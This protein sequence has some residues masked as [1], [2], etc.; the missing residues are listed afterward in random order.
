MVRFVNV[1]FLVAALPSAVLAQRPSIPPQAIAGPA[2]AVRAV[3]QSEALALPGD[4]ELDQVA[5]VAIDDRGHLFVLHRGDPPLLE[6]ETD[7]SFVRGIGA[8]LFQR[9]HGLTLDPNGGFWVTDV[10]AHTVMHLDS[11]GNVL[12]ALGTPGESGVWDEATG[13]QRFDQPNDVALGPDGHV[14]V[15]Q[16]HGRGDPKILKFDPNG[17]LLKSW[18]GRGTLPWQFAVAHSIAID[19]GGLLYVADREN[20][21]IQIYDRDGNFLRGWVYRGMACSLAFGAD[22]KLYMTTGF[23]GQIVQLD[24]DG[25]VLGVTGKPGEGLNEYGEAHDL[26]IATSGDIYVAD[27]VNRRLQKLAAVSAAAAR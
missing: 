12:M 9:A 17:K 16:G 19:P 14:F 2:L 13:S 4:I 22:A 23:D 8:G 27:V 25:H 18:G 6:F 1:S 15:A 20:R 10:A 7:G 11:D 3:E 21:R 5:S 24:L 26:A